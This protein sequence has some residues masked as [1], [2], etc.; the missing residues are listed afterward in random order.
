MHPQLDPQEITRILAI[1]PEHTLAAR[2]RS[3]SMASECYWIAPL[4]FSELEEPWPQP[5]ER[6]GATAARRG[7]RPRATA[8]MQVLDDATAVSLAVRRL[9]V[10]Q[11]FF[12]RVADEGGSATLLLN[13]NKA[14]S[15]TIPPTLAQKL[16]ELG[17]ALEVDWSEELD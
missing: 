17:L 4:L 15:M 7:R 1:D 10:H 3:A 14:G 9:Q 11:D 2:R 6:F 5:G 13:V 16:A 12:R 8:A